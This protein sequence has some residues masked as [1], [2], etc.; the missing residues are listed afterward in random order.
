MSDMVHSLG[1][2]DLKPA[3]DYNV[4]IV[5]IDPAEKPPMAAAKKAS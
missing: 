5:S 4:V 1:Q 3:Q 2:V